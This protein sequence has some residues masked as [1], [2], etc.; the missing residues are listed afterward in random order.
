MPRAPRLC[1]GPGPCQHKARAHELCTGH[2]AQRD[3]GGPLAPL[4]ERAEVRREVVSL[5]VSPECRE[6]VLAKP[7]AARL[8]LEHWARGPATG[9]ARPALRRKRG[10]GR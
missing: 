6:R 10:G 9:P 2:L 8:V 1:T 4:A 7:A 3:Q 5:R